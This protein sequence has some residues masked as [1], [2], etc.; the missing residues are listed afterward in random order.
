[1]PTKNDCEAS[2]LGKRVFRRHFSNMAPKPIRLE[3][4]KINTIL[5]RPSSRHF[6]SFQL[7]PIFFLIQTPFDWTTWQ[8]EKHAWTGVTS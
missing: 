5:S 4:C 8:A 7:S 2:N 3:G 1:M 6:N